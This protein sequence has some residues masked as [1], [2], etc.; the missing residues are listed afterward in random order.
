MYVREGMEDSNV[1]KTFALAS[2]NSTKRV[3]VAEE[4]IVLIP[5]G[6]NVNW[7]TRADNVNILTV[8][9][10]WT[11]IRWY[12]RDMDSVS[13]RIRVSVMTGLPERIASI[14]SVMVQFP[15]K[16]MSVPVTVAASL[17]TLASVVMHIMGWIARIR[18]ASASPILTRMSVRLMEFAMDLISVIARVVGFREIVVSQ[19]VSVFGAQTRQ[20]ALAMDRVMN[21][22]YVSVVKAE[23]E[24]I[25]SSMPVLD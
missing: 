5:T 7:V 24:I 18:A 1:N 4:A 20:F 13:V 23:Q 10:G 21:Q 11:Y 25:V 9:A 12:V 2:F 22:M 14:P 15:M 6:A 8:S 16:P 3:C 17:R 19:H